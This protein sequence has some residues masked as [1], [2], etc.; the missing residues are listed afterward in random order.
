MDTE[1]T[2]TATVQIDDERVRVTEWRFAPGTQTGEHTHEYDYVVVPLTTGTLQV[3]AEGEVSEN[4]LVPGRSYARGAGT[5]HN[6]VNASDSECAFVEV[7]LR[8]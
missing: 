5:T 4:V 7:E 8:S 2:A 6:V 3:H 1:T